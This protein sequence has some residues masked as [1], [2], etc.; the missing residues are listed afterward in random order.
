MTDSLDEILASD[1]P[2]VVVTGL[3][4]IVQHRLGAMA[5]DEL[6]EPQ[7]ILLVIY[8]LI[9]EVDNGG[10]I[11][12]LGNSSG[13]HVA[14]ARAALWTLGAT[15]ALGILD[16][17]VSTLGAGVAHPDRATR[18]AVLEA[19]DEDAYDAIEPLN[20]AFYDAPDLYAAVAA[21]CRVHA[22]AFRAP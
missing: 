1:D 4:P 17:V 2:V 8:E 13:D 19:L 9:S 16:E 11:Q 5:V 6:P 20:D 15:D 12:Y 22:G 21:H 3:L 10:F 18:A 14:H 7:R